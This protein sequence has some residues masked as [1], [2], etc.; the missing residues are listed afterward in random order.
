[1]ANIKP[2]II[3]LYLF[4]FFCHPINKFLLRPFILDNDLPIILK[5]FTLSVPNVIEA[6]MGTNVVTGLLHLA[7]H[8]LGW[9]QDFN[10]RTVYS[11]SVTIASI[12]VIT[13][14]FKI[15]H[16]GGR[17]TYDPYDVIASIIGLIIIYFLLRRY[18]FSLDSRNGATVR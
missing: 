9:F 11:F 12:Y 13:Q 16:L 3:R 2:Y 17:N 14:E 6:V 18:G 10:E 7:Q 5:I 1:M 15:H 4:L 8:R